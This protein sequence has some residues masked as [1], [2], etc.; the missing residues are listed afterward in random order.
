MSSFL[1]TS[2]G[3]AKR[4][5]SNGI[6]RRSAPFSARV[7]VRGERQSGKSSLVSVLAG[8]GFDKNYTPTDEIVRRTIPFVFAPRLE[9]GRIELWDVVDRSDDS[10]RE[11][12]RESIQVRLQRGADQTPKTRRLPADARSVD[13]YRPL[14]DGIIF[15][16][17]PLLASSLDYA[18]AQA[19]V[20]VYKSPTT[21]IL[22]VAG[23]YDVASLAGASAACLKALSELATDLGDL[24]GGGARATV[25]QVSLRRSLGLDEVRR[26]L[27]LPYAAARV[28]ALEAQ[29][30]TAEDDLAR[31]RAS[32]AT[33]P[34]TP[35]S[36]K[37]GATA[38]ASTAGS[39]SFSAAST[40]ASS[41]PLS[42]ASS[43]GLASPTPTGPRSDEARTPA[44]PTPSA[45]DVSPTTRTPP[46]SAIETAAAVSRS[47]P[48]KKSTSNPPA[49]IG[50]RLRGVFRLRPAAEEG[51]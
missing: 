14:P 47:T 8:L 37:P 1:R 9:E 3:S 50:S 27:D 39:R 48:G 16:V 32:L 35:A 5:A 51:I 17:N 44:P 21:P 18:V 42:P 7:L 2:R 49:S 40:T 41:A 45:A 25:V 28:R 30:A 38:S 4:D 31:I 10:D 12:T 36:P 19:S 22:I 26:W 34:R 46:L 11:A 20:A 23:H 43:V 6:V 15:I 33:L 13:V 29:L 24:P